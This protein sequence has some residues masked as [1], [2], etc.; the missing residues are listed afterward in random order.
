MIQMFKVNDKDCPINTYS[1]TDV[2]G[3]P[4]TTPAVKMKDG[5]FE[6]QNYQVL[7]ANETLY[8]M[9]ETHGLVREFMRISVISKINSP[10][11]FN[12]TLETVVVDVKQDHLDSGA[13]KNQTY[14]S[15]MVIDLQLNE[16]NIT[17]TGELQVP[18]KCINVTVTEN[19]FK[20]EIMRSKIT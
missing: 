15:P 6:I 2:D 12:G 13:T 5:G 11:E 3:N 10:P 4:L 19:Q 17:I 1:F 16:I 18:C 14:E 8:L 9:A 20:L 7:D